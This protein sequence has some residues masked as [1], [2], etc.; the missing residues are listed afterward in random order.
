MFRVRLRA[1]V[2]VRIRVCELF[3]LNHLLLKVLSVNVLLWNQCIVLGSCLSGVI[4]YFTKN[5]GRNTKQHYF[6]QM[7]QQS[8]F[9]V[10]FSSDNVDFHCCKRCLEGGPDQHV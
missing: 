5:S 7:S 9:L 10:F 3:V 1:R 2:G 6:F 4:I 8:R